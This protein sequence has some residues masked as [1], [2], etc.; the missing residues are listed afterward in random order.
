MTQPTMVKLTRIDLQCGPLVLLRAGLAQLALL[1]AQG[2]A[3]HARRV[4]LVALAPPA[5]L[6]VAGRFGHLVARGLEHDG[7]GGAVGGAALHDPQHAHVP[8]GAR[9]DPADGPRHARAGGGEAPGAQDRSFK[10]SC[11]MASRACCQRS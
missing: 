3:G 8:A 11:G 7:Q 6:G 4:Q 1:Q 2:G 10:Y 5:L 9:A